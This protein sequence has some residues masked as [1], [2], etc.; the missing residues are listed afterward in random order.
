MSALD[1]DYAAAGF[2]GHLPFGR[3]P[4]LL[5]VDVC[6]A[7]LDP[8]S[9]LY[10][11]GEEVLACNVRLIDA[12]RT[13]RLPVIFTRVLY[14]ADGADGGLFYRKVPALK[15]YLEASPLREFP[16]GFGPRDDEVVVTKQY[17]SAF[18]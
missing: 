17:A 7:Y 5:I 6:N 2:N 11:A 10:A 3:Q 12:A 18:F 14:C 1:A 9:P 13:A 8:T 4:A 15:A 16:P